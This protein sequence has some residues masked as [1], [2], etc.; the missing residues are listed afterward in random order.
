[1]KITFLGL[2]SFLIENK[3]GHKILI[4][5]FNDSPEWSFGLNFPKTIEGK[6]L[7]AELV[8]LSHMDADH[9]SFR[10]EVS[11][12]PHGK[13][14]HKASEYKIRFP[15]LNL[16][17][18]LLSEWNG[19]P[20][21]GWSYN[22]DGFNLWHL[23]DNVPLLTKS[24]IKEAGKID[25]LFIS[26]TKIAGNI[27]T[28]LKN[29]KNIDPKYVVWAHHIPVQPQNETNLNKIRDYY[30]KT[31][32]PQ[33]ANKGADMHAVEVFTAYMTNIFEM[34][35]KFERVILI[36]KPSYAVN[37]KKSPKPTVLFFRRSAQK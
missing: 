30:K 31:I 36:D 11:I 14:D 32:L 16:H 15:I 18:V 5:P 9:A 10:P 22:I 24:Q 12:E 29:I 23:A 34:N 13:K 19:Y 33:K 28:T 37:N 25:I 35:K 6:C 3:Y 4:D 7:T 20:N 17:G 26:P 21:I 1:M 8:L 2:S 27:Q